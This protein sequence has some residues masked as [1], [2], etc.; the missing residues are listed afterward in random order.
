MAIIKVLI[1]TEAE[2]NQFIS[3]LHSTGWQVAPEVTQACFGYGGTARVGST[4]C[5]WDAT[6]C[7]APSRD[8]EKTNI[9]AELTLTTNQLATHLKELR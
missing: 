1:R 5:V 9:E 7:Y 8:F 2:A 3:L 6:M 4:A